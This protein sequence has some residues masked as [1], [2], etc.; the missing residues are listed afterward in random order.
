MAI[1]CRA[2]MDY[3]LLDVTHPAGTNIG[4]ICRFIV[5]DVI[6]SCNHGVYDEDIVLFIYLCKIREK[7]FLIGLDSWVAKAW[8]VWVVLKNR[9]S[10]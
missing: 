10:S 5:L 7:S 3:M 8:E 4:L 1:Q 2:V 9:E 6:Y